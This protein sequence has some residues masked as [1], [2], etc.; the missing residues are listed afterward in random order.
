MLAFVGQ[1]QYTALQG[2]ISMTANLK[3]LV[4]DLKLLLKPEQFDDYCPNGLQLEGRSVVRKIF[5]WRHRVQALGNYI[6]D[7]FSV[8]HQ[9]INIHNPV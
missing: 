8:S 5:E 7:K 1:S 2:Q 4:A 3:E 6:A 9:F